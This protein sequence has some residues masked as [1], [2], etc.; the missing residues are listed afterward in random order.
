[1]T[2]KTLVAACML[3]SLTGTSIFASEESQRPYYLSENFQE[4]QEKVQDVP[5]PYIQDVPIPY[6][7]NLTPKQRER[8]WR[9]R[10]Q[11]LCE[12]HCSI[13]DR[14]QEIWGLTLALNDQHDQHRTEKEEMIRSLLEP[15][16]RKEEE[17]RIAK[18]EIKEKKKYEEEGEEEEEEEEGEEEGEDRFDIKFFLDLYGRKDTKEGRKLLKADIKSAFK[19]DG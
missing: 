19:I 14:H 2:N 8:F 12:E 10:A 9:Q 6:I 16:R 4:Y 13:A 7:G 11:I 1:M 3:L 15:V 5:I 18:M 17:R